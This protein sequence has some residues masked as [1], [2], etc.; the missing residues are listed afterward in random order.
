MDFFG[1]SVFEDVSTSVCSVQL[2][3]F[4]IVYFSAF[5]VIFVSSVFSLCVTNVELLSYNC[6]YVM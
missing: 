2:Y 5:L 4:I 3:I 6:I 1:H